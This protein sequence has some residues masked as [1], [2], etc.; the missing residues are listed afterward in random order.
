MQAHVEQLAHGGRVALEGREAHVGV[1]RLE[2]GD[3][4][5]RGSHARR[6]LGLGEA[7]LLAAATGRP[8]EV[9]EADTELGRYL[10]AEAALQYGLVDEIW[11]K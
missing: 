9:V 6:H 7:Q 2:A 10:D 5:L 1:A 11:R 8:F 3:C 4:G